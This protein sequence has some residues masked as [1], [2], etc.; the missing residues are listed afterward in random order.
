MRNLAFVIWLIGADLEMAIGW[1][2]DFLQGNP[3]VFSSFDLLPLIMYI[4]I[5]VLLYERKPKP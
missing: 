3:H 2:L 5:A 1:H 4:G